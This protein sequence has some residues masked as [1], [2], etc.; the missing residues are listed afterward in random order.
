MVKVLASRPDRGGGEVTEPITTP[1]PDICVECGEG[2]KQHGIDVAWKWG[3]DQTMK[4]KL[5]RFT[6]YQWFRVGDETGPLCESC[7]SKEVEE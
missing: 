7:A 6:V 4:S 3:R 5:T 2:L 1:S